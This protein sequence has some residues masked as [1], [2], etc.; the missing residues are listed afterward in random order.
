MAGLFE[1]YLLFV[2]REG[3]GGWDFLRDLGVAIK[4]AETLGNE[5]LEKVFGLLKGSR[6][7]RLTR[8]AESLVIR[9]YFILASSRPPSPSF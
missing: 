7:L 9:Q 6:A 3:G 2:G 4:T 1:N 5:G 8:V